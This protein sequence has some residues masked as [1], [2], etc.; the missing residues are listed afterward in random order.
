MTTPFRRELPPRAN[1]AQQKT[2]ARE[3]LQAFTR[4]DTNAVTRVRAI[5]PDKPRIVLADAQFVL[6][7]E[8]GFH[9]RRTAPVRTAIRTCTS[10]SP[11][12]GSGRTGPSCRRPHTTR[13]A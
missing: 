2:Q 9:D 13:R 7:R 6:A 3:L 8:Y 12:A 4:S 5:L 10:S 11:A 1:L